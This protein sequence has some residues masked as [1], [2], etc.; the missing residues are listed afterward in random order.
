MKK[1]AIEDADAEMLEVFERV[2]AEAKREKN[3]VPPINK[4]MYYWTRKPLIVG[5]AV[6]LACTLEKPS[7][8]ESL[9]G[10][11]KDTRAYKSPPRQAEYRR[12]L[13]KDPTKISMLDPFAGTGNLAFPSVELGLDVSCSDYNP[14]AYLI[15]RGSLEIP[16][17]YDPTLAKEFESVANKIIDDVEHTVGK[18][19]KSD[20]LVHMWAW[21]I[22]CVH[23]GQRVPLLNQMYLAKQKDRGKKIGLRFNPTKNKNFVV[24]IDRD[25]TTEH[26]KSFTQKGGRV[27]CI[28]CGNTT[29]YDDMRND[30]AKNC[31]IE[32]LAVQIKK[33]EKQGRD[34]VLPTDMDRKQYN[35]SLKFFNNNYDDIMKL[36]PNESVL[37]SHRK[38]HTL[39]LYGIKNW[40]KFFSKRQLLVLSTLVRRINEFCA[41][42][43]ENPRMPI[44]RIYLS[45]LVARLVNSYSYGTVWDSGTEK[46]ATALSLRQPRIVFNLVE[47]NP[48]AKVRGSLRNNA[49]NITKAIEFCARLKSPIRCKMESV[50]V[51]AD[52][53]YDLIITDP[54]Y[55]DDVQ[56]GE[57]SEFFYLWMYRTLGDKTLPARAPLDEDFCES[58]GRFGD[59]KLAAEF[60]EKGLK[61]SFVAVN[62]KLKDDGLMAV[63]FAHSSTQTWNQLL[64][65]LRAGGFRVVSS[66]ALHTENVNNPLAH[67]KTSFMSSIVVACRKIT[68]N[69]S[70]FLEDVIPDT[71]DGIKETLDKI[72]TA[73]LLA[74]PFTDL[75]IMVYGKVLE[76]CTKYKELKSRSNDRE[77]DFEM[78]LS[79]AQSVV[80]RLLISRLAK[81]SMSVVG[82]NMAFY[83]L[84]KVFQSGRV[85]ADDMLKI[86]KA[87]NMD[88]SDL[89]K[90]DMVVRD[91]NSYGLSYLHQNE[92]DFPADNVERDDLHQQL[93]YLA[94]QV[95]MGRAKDVDAILDGEN[96]KRAT[97]KQ[98]VHLI[99]QSIAMRRNRGA[100][101][102]GHDRD[103]IRILETLADMMGVRSEGG[104]DAFTSGT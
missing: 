9:L 57:M 34:Y 31:D 43:G 56:Y 51:P 27:Q 28:S 58:Q 17:S 20:T 104:L 10:L 67:N 95:D 102:D 83:I 7:Q 101:L 12:L 89:I 40:N 73:K 37:A 69:L 94:R 61:K 103:E 48:F 71:E 49:A 82:P 87:Y 35:K 60:F 42:S 13:G 65:S 19:Y 6:A 63:F 4:M 72:P 26:G 11:S 22:K 74:L 5:R 23:C 77:P 90:S 54:P 80:M 16:A 38:E 64:L 33:S 91:G 75:L 81:S 55:G 25:V 3:A 36:V 24:E 78:V 8:V 84:V 99:L 14:L 45:F 15:M 50:T 46:L 53:Q 93:C 29:N 30:I 79:N 92:M 66:Y 41:A 21:C 98:I 88:P 59:K 52:K 68:D 39:H 97:L 85:S 96:F 47:I 70:G 100:S 18:F 32:L 44:F 1:A 76:S 2:S 62:K 86:T